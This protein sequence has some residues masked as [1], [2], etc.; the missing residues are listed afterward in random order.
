M[1]Q[2]IES[3]P[4]TIAR[5]PALLTQQGIDNV[6]HAQLAQVRVRLTCADE[7]YREACRPCRGE[8]GADFV[9]RC[10]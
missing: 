4:A 9:L 3:E 5:Y 6:R 8:R 10:K 7:K 2:D 1:K